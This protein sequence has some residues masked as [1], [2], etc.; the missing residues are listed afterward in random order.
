MMDSLNVLMAESGA[1][2]AQPLLPIQPLPPAR[3][4]RKPVSPRPQ[5]CQSAAAMPPRLCQIWRGAASL[6]SNAAP[7]HIKV[8]PNLGALCRREL[9]EQ[10]VSFLAEPTAAHAQFA[11]AIRRRG[12]AAIGLPP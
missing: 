3:L 8:V 1:M 11:G 12:R 7:H 4:L 10:P 9:T 6:I 2:H 5:L